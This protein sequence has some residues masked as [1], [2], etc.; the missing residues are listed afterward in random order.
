M[1]STAEK[2][3]KE[4]KIQRTAEFL[5]SLVL[6]H[7]ITRRTLCELCAKGTG[8]ATAFDSALIRCRE[9]RT[10]INKLCENNRQN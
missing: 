10:E 1:H 2:S 6:Q 5:T 4:Q 8:N 9:L 3:K 7:N